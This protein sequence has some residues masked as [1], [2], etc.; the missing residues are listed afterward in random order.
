MESPEPIEPTPHR[1][2]H[3]IVFVGVLV[4]LF[5]IDQV[6][7]AWARHTFAVNL[8]AMHGA[9]FPGVFEL[10]L[11]YNEG[12]AFG[13]FQGHGVMLTPIAVLMAGG[14]GYYSFKSAKEPL[15][16]HIAL[17]LL[18]SGA[19]GNLYDRLVL[20]HVTDMFFFRLINFPVFNV[21]DSC[22]TVSAILLIGLWLTESLRSNKPKTSETSPS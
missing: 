17:A 18:A 12:V 6:V 19:L 2:D 8:N 9:P 5:V 4:L 7:K 14:A 10:T 22:I 13:M 15:V 11:T 1:I 21:A 3:R 20:G 16:T